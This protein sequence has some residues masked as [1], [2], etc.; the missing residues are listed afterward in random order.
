MRVVFFGTPEFAVPCLDALV[1]AGHEVVLVVSQPDK[2]SGRGQETKS[3]PVVERARALGLDVAQPKALKSGPFPERLAALA[4]DVACVV[5]YGRI[6]PKALLEAPKH[7]CVNVHASL[8]PRWRGAAPIQAAVL[9]GDLVTGV[10]TQRMVEELDAGDV[11][12]RAAVP[13]DAR[14]TAGTLHDKLSG[15]GARVLVAT[16]AAMPGLEPRPQDPSRVTFA[17]KIEKD[18]GRVDWSGDAAAID[19]QVRAMT[20]WP[21]GWVPWEGGPLKLLE[22]APVEGSGA[23]GTLL[24]VDPLVVACGNG[25]LRLVRVQAPGRRAVRGADF[26]NGARLVVGA[27]LHREG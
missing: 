8:L 26:A 25:A 23:P 7:G 22:V 5:A 4:P 24:S 11:Y 19:R 27:D 16:L 9:A 3:P 14:E 15:A 12:L 10:C 1:D 20:P 18:G 13:T 17:G 2:P 21:G 6:L